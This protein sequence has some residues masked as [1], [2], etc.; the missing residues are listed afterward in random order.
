MIRLSE[1][2]F[3]YS[4]PNTENKNNKKTNLSYNK[5]SSFDLRTIL[6]NNYE[7][8]NFSSDNDEPF[9]FS[10]Y[11]KRHKRMIDKLKDLKNNISFFKFYDLIDFPNKQ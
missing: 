8:Q 2:D 7:E 5:Y 9:S 10:F 6:K 1:K 3:F 11:T 4:I